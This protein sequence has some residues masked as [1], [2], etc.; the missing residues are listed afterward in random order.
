MSVHLIGCCQY[1]FEIVITTYMHP[2]IRAYIHTQTTKSMTSNH[3]DKKLEKR[4]GNHTRARHLRGFVLNIIKDGAAI[5]A[6]GRDL[7]RVPAQG[8]PAT[9]CLAS[10][11]GHR[12]PGMITRSSSFQQSSITH[13]IGSYYGW[14]FPPAFWA[15]HWNFLFNISCRL[16]EICARTWRF[17]VFG[18][19]RR[20]VHFAALGAHHCRWNRR[21][22][23]GRRT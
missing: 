16:T 8:V 11:R 12:I 23:V 10:T 14:V 13:V 5:R 9:G 2:S 4:K 3:L 1:T 21:Q 18:F 22:F 20:A 17:R 15:L 7:L 6:F 19:G